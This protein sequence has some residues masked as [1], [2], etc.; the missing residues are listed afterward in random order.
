MSAYGLPSYASQYTGAVDL[1]TNAVTTWIQIGSGA[2][3]DVTSNAVTPAFLAAG[4]RILTVTVVNR[5]T[6]DAF[7]CLTARD[8][9]HPSTH[10]I[11][12]PGEQTVSWD[13]PVATRV[14]TISIKKGAGADV[15]DVLCQCDD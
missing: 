15:V 11:R 6:N 3:Y 14:T 13:A 2:L 8:A 10:S 7:L 4:H 1:T 9:G 5:S 12:I